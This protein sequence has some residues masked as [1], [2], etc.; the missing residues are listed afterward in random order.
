MGEGDK[1]TLL[2]TKDGACLCGVVAI[3]GTVGEETAFCLDAKVTIEV[4][5]GAGD[6]AGVD[7]LI[8]KG[9][10]FAVERM[11]VG[12]AAVEIET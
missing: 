11:E 1:A 12:V 7:R 5:R 2:I 8:D 6:C 9:A 4:G 3:I 10:D